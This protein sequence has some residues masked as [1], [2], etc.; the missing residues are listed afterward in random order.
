MGFALS[1]KPSP[2]AHR[3]RP[4]QPTQAE[5]DPTHG[6]SDLTFSVCDFGCRE[7][8]IR[9]PLFQSLARLRMISRVPG[10]RRVGGAFSRSAEPPNDPFG[11]P[12][13]AH[14]TSRTVHGTPRTVHGTPRTAH[15]APRPAHGLPHP[16]RGSPRTAQGAPRAAHG[17]PRTAHGA[18]RTAQGSPRTA[19]GT[20]RTAHGTPRTA[21]GTA[22]SSGG[23]FFSGGAGPSLRSTIGRPPLR[24]DPTKWKYRAIYRIDDPPPRRA[25]RAVERRG[26]R[27]G[28][29]VRHAG[30]KRRGDG[31]PRT[32][33]P[34][35]GRGPGFS[36]KMRKLIA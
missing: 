16:A 25:L 12:R 33:S 28:G 35:P 5:S 36:F 32:R 24:Q 7:T 22:H 1:Q 3:D 27:D 2:G 20:P 13:A 6:I 4:C 26:E 29:G 23:S 30:K 17:T 21:Q 15:G 31:E 14:G 9:K 8:S 11:V 10:R 34:D 18:P 19:H